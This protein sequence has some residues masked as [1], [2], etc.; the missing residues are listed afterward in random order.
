MVVDNP[1]L[2]PY[3]LGDATA[4][5]PHLKPPPLKPP[6]CLWSKSYSLLGSIFFSGDM[7]IGGRVYITPPRRQ[8]IPGI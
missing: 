2:R 8:Y 7:V 5:P 1:L 6:S 3:F 4:P